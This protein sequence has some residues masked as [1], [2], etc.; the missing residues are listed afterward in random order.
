MNNI[1][2][3]EPIA[4]TS[5]RPRARITGAVYLLYFLT[6]IFAAFLGTRH[7]AYGDA[8]NLIANAFYIVVTLL[9]YFL[10]KP[11]NRVLSL[12]AA[13]FSVV[14]CAIQTLSLYHLA[15]SRISPLLFFGPY[16]LLLG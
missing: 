16:C 3:K 4:E 1:V 15:S 13:C 9:F 6:A 12:L 11:V 10:F 14:G 7:V 8:A 5:Q 2:T